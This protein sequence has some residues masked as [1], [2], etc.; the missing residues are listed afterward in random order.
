MELRRRCEVD[1][2][3]LVLRCASFSSLQYCRLSSRIVQTRLENNSKSK[4]PLD[5]VDNSVNLMQSL[6]FAF[7]HETGHEVC[8]LDPTLLRFE[9]G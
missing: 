6:Q 2:V 4:F 8:E 7:L 5:A 9:N 3:T 1:L